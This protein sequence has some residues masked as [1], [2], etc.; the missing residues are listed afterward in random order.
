MKKMFKRYLSKNI[1]KILKIYQKSIEKENFDFSNYLDTNI[2]F[3]I[4]YLLKL[5]KERKEEE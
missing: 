2:Y 5:I 1:I 4:E 3:E